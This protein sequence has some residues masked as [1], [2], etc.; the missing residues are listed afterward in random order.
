MPQIRLLTGADQDRIIQLEGED[1]AEVTVGRDPGCDIVLDVDS[2]ASRRHATVYRADGQ[3]RIKDLGSVN[4]TL[5]NRVR[6]ADSP[7]SLGDKVSIAT[8]EF[9]YEEHTETAARLP[10]Q[11]PPCLCRIFRR[12]RSAGDRPVDERQDQTH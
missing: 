3:W 9:A 10:G 12:S 2:P 1:N 5:V 6:I 4:G 8:L 11:S 7:L